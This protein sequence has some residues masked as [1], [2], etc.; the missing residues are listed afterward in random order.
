[1]ILSLLV[2]DFLCNIYDG[3]DDL[4]DDFNDGSDGN[5]NDNDNDGSRGK[6][7]SKHL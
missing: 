2:G 4:N 1:M 6:V 7:S 5:R 3:N